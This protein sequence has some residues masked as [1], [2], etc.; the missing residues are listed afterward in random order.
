MKTKDKGWME[1]SQ[2]KLGVIGGMGPYATAKFM[3]GIISHTKADKDQDHIDMVVL[4]H[5]KMPDR[6]KT[7]EE[8]TVAVLL[9]HFKEALSILEFSKVD[10]IA[11]PCNTSHYYYDEIQ[12]MTQI[13]II[14]MIDETCKHIADLYPGEKIAV[15]ATDGTVNSGVYEKYGKK[16]GLISVPL[17]K[18]EQKIVMDTIYNMKNKKVIHS[19][20]FNKILEYYIEN[21]IHVILACTELS[22]LVI[23][24]ELKNKTI[25]AMDILMKESVTRCKKEWIG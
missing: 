16:R 11:I 15:L 7:I 8:G 19:D 5:C 21:K 12:A 2:C 17:E 18:F 9:A 10:Q 1:M 22:S 23:P 6:T 4:N 24:H 25:D 20:E 14:N 3:E 13:P